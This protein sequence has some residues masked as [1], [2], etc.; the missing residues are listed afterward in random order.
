MSSRHFF[1]WS[2]GTT[3]AGLVWSPWNSASQSKSPRHVFDCWKLTSLHWS[4]LQLFDVLKMDRKWGYHALGK[5]YEI[6]IKH[7][8]P[9][10]MAQQPQ[11]K[12]LPYISGVTRCVFHAL[13]PSQQ[14]A[15]LEAWPTRFLR[16]ICLKMEDWP[17][18]TPQF[19]GQFSWE[20][21]SV[22]PWNLGE[23]FQ[24]NPVRSLATLFSDSKRSMYYDVIWCHI[25]PGTCEFKVETHVRDW[26]YG[27]VL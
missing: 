9:Q 7:V 26:W 17:G 11:K 4:Q 21:E 16:Q 24:T 23:L 3:S 27:G 14:I 12:T 8:L 6:W 18:L 13:F 20:H 2:Q 10:E 25:L 15:W 19:N 22:V 5:I 1:V